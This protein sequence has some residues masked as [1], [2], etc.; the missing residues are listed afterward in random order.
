MMRGIDL[1]TIAD[2]TNGQLLGNN[3]QINN[4]TIDSREVGLGDMFLSLI[5]I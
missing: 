4:I 5:H 3:I 2:A 1:K